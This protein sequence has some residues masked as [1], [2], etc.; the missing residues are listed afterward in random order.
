MSELASFH[1]IVHG[2]V[3]KVF[4]RA[5][6]REHGCKLGLKG[7]VRNIPGGKSIEVQAEGEKEALLELLKSIRVGPPVAKV[8]KVD[9]EWLDY[10]G[11]FQDFRVRY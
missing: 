10:S 8:G 9:V 3:Q 11:S 5:F 6:V 7:F 2:R 4:F 1:A